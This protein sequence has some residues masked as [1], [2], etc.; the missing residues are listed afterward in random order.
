[1]AAR[2]I[3]DEPAQVAANA[4]TF[5]GKAAAQAHVAKRLADWKGA[6][7]ETMEAGTRK[8]N[9]GDK[10]VL[11]NGEDSMTMLLLF[12]KTQLVEVLG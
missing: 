10:Y 9:S 4:Y 3:I 8:F 1:M 6:T 2:A 12:D 7:I 11:T 5:V